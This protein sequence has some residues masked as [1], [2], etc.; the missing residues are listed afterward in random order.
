MFLGSVEKGKFLVEV[1]LLKFDK[2]NLTNNITAC[3]RLHLELF[4]AREHFY[5]WKGVANLECFLEWQSCHSNAEGSPK[6]LYRRNVSLA[7]HFTILYFSFYQKNKFA[8][9]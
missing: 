5:I 7:V 8:F 2:L 1:S 4:F 9:V 3:F 6:L